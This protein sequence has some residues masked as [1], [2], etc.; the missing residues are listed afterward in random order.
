M[1]LPE[2]PRFVA[3]AIIG[4]Q[5]A[6]EDFL[7]T[8]LGDTNLAAIHRNRVTICQ[9]DMQLVRKLRSSM[10]SHETDIVPK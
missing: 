10:A 6:A 8:L 9:K 5:T 4:L 1:G 2:N 7:V 3:S